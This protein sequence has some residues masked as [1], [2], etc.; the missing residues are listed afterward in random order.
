MKWPGVKYV[1]IGL[2]IITRGV[3]MEEIRV[4]LM[5]TIIYLAKE[6]ESVKS[7][8]LFCGFVA[9]LEGKMG[10]GGDGVNMEK[11]ALWM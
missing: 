7:G 4:G 10:D 9:W 5:F 8:Q 6:V 2:K 1:V 11:W 3:F